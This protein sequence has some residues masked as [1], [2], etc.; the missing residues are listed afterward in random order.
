MEFSVS[1]RARQSAGFV[2]K[3]NPQCGD[4]GYDKTTGLQLTRMEHEADGLEFV[5]PDKSTDSE[6]SGDG[7]SGSSAGSADGSGFF[8]QPIRT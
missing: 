4:G 6:G 1:S 5:V 2:D 8:I 3:T 7:R